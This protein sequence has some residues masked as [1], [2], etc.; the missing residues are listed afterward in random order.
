MCL[1]AP[2]LFAR[3]FHGG[4]VGDLSTGSHGAGLF[5]RCF[6]G[7]GCLTGGVV[8]KVSKNR[9]LCFIVFCKCCKTPNWSQTKEE[10]KREG[11]Q[12]RR[13]FGSIRWAIHMVWR[14][15]CSPAPFPK[16]PVRRPGERVGRGIALSGTTARPP[17]AQRAG[18]IPY[19]CLHVHLDLCLAQRHSRHSSFPFRLFRLR[20]TFPIFPF[21]FSPCW[22]LVV[23]VVVVVCFAFHPFILSSFRRCC[24]CCC[25]TAHTMSSF[26]LQLDALWKL[27]AD[28][29]MTCQCCHKDLMPPSGFYPL[30]PTKA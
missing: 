8:E 27:H 22:P 5:A 11:G 19:L 20:A 21:L 28:G 15:R 14:K 12:Q 4:P 13:S 10:N 29:R 25:C 3:F 17:V 24:C 6:Y 30:T 23:V 2:I 26:H 1:D 16:S 9:K 18:G 7:G